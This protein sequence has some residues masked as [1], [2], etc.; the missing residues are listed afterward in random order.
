VKTNLQSGLHAINDPTRLA[1]LR[2]IAEQPLAVAQLAR[3]FPLTRPAISQHLRI[4]KDSG[5]VN[6]VPKGAQRIYHIDPSGIEALKAHFDAL[7]SSV[8]TNFKAA[9]ERS[10]DPTPITEMSHAR[11]QRHRTRRKRS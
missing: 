1:I 10:Q 9:A 8:L 7:W 2:R 4:L 11:R 3:H 5:L 6:D